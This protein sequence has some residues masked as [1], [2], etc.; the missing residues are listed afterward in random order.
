MLVNGAGTSASPFVQLEPFRI[1]VVDDNPADRLLY[2][3]SLPGNADRVFEIAEA[4]NGEA[5]LAACRACRP[6]CIVLDFNLPNMD[7][8]EFM[9]AVKRE[10]G[11]LPCPIVMLTGVRDER[12]AVRAMKS[13]AADYI[14]KS[15]NIA[16]ALERA[17][18]GAI[19]KSRMR[20]QIE[21]QRI[22]L[23]A[24]ERRHRTLL[25]A[26]PQLVWVADA[27]GNVEYANRR[28]WEYTGLDPN[29][30]MRMKDA[31][32][33][34]DRER[35]WN[36]R[37]RA[38]ASNSP[39][40]MEVRLRRAADRSDRWHL[41]RTVVMK[42]SGEDGKWLGT[43]TDIEDLKRAERA[44]QQ[45]QKWESIGLLAGG[46]AHDFNNLLVGILGGAS[47]AADVLPPNHSI[48]PTLEN[49]V[50]SGERAA[51]LTRQ[52]L[53]YSGQGNFFL[54]QVDLSAAVKE[55]FQLVRALIP[56][57]VRL[58]VHTAD[59]LPPIETDSGQMQQVIMN[60]IVNAAEAIPENQTGTVSVWTSAEKIGACSA[61]PGFAIPHD[62]LD[63]I[64]VILEVHDTGC[65]M[66]E[67]TKSKIFDPFF[68]TKFTGRGLGLAAVQG[69]LRSTGG[70]ITVESAPGQGSLFRV[71]VPAAQ[72]RALTEPVEPVSE[73][74]VEQ[75]S[76]D[77][78]LIVDDEAVV[79]QIA[80]IALERA[81]YQVLTAADGP[82]G[83][84][85]LEEHKDA[86]SLVLL[87]MGMPEMS[88]KEVLNKIRASGSKVPVVICSGYS[89]PEV[90][91]Q[92]ANCDFTAVIQKPFKSKELPEGVGR[93]LKGP[94]PW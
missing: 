30:R 5:A 47:Y 8:L 54:E 66:D 88:G 4:D 21:E 40:E 72:T 32:H 24:S 56:P 86:I 93:A 58:D 59:E 70:W 31:V 89:E 37:C 13:G 19:E 14:P 64:F 20:R 61:P 46:I 33:A 92:F 69:I 23:A 17:I 65:G 6:D 44:I 68:T 63:G 55:T 75:A 53:A 81:G 74:P 76:G 45:K 82:T 1:L 84:T 35:Y 67:E 18:M 50:K 57:N 48:Q 3:M 42:E 85:M 73:A 2:R 38:V 9:S 43:C 79:R 62:V 60:L 91:R 22:A 28:W 77:T 29:D 52:M 27:E 15:D 80:Q 49:I 83:L 7:G 39:F 41:I 94:K 12:I 10:F 11:D 78:V 71:V 25:E 51:Q 87:D 26:L 34:E 36:A 16:D 90:L